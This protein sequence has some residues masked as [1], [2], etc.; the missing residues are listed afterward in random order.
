LDKIFDKFNDLDKNFDK[1]F[2][3]LDKKSDKKFNDLDN[4]FQLLER[5]I[6]LTYE[7][8]I[9]SELKERLETEFNIKIRKIDSALFRSTRNDKRLITGFKGVSNLDDT[10]FEKLRKASKAQTS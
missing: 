4:K 8:Q 10:D 1:K 7:L 5:K 2:N 9:K 3:N 6:T